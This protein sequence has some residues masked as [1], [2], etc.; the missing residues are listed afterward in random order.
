MVEF[1]A[2]RL[3]VVTLFLIGANLTRDVF[4]TVGFQPLAQAILLWLIAASASLAA[5]M[6]EVIK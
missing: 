6:G 3:L 2:R 1:A 4:K 5:I